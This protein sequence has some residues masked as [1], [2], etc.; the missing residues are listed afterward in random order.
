[1]AERTIGVLSNAARAMLYD[2]ALPDSLWAE[3]FNTA[4]YVHNRA[5]TRALDG[6]TPFEVRYG[7]KPDLAHL[8]AFGAPRAVVQ[9]LEELRKLDARSRMG[10]FVGYKYEGGGYRV[11]DHAW[12][13]SSRPELS[14]SPPPALNESHQQSADADELVVQPAPICKCGSG[15][16]KVTRSGV[17]NINTNK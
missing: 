13:S 15:V 10:F 8:H 2:S 16:N 14:F 11:W 1:V 3:A 4:T 17:W 12:G 9:P 6:R 7:A 5:P